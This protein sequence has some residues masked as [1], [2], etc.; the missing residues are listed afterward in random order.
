MLLLVL[1]LVAPLTAANSINPPL[2]MKHR[3]CSD[4][5]TSGLGGAACGQLCNDDLVLE[6][7]SL[8]KK[9]TVALPQQHHVYGPRRAVCPLLCRN[10]LGDPLCSCHVSSAEVTKP[11]NWTAICDSFCH[12]EGYTLYGC[13]LCRVKPSGYEGWLSAA[14]YSTAEESPSLQWDQLCAYLCSIG[15]GGAACNCDAVP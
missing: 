8:L 2:I 12:E 7:Q 1:V 10:H 5:C 6:L 15:E 14:R 13:S 4:L 9:Q 11:V 3:V